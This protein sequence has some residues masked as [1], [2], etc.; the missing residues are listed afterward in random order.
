MDMRKVISAIVVAVVLIGGAAVAYMYIADVGVFEKKEVKEEKDL[1]ESKLGEFGDSDSSDEKDKGKG[2][3]KD[4]ETGS[5]KGDSVKEDEEDKNSDI[6]SALGSE[7]DTEVE[8][9]NVEVTEGKDGTARVTADTSNG[10][11]IDVFVPGQ[12]TGGEPVVSTDKPKEVEVVLENSGANKN[13]EKVKDLIE[14]AGATYSGDVSTGSF[15]VSGDGIDHV[16]SEGEEDDFNYSYSVSREDSKKSLELAA[17][18]MIKLGVRSSKSVILDSI[19][20]SLSGEG[21]E[22][23]GF[24]V[25]SDGFGTT[26]RWN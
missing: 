12:S 2:T 14:K 8:V 3:D 4:K 26:V 15:G 22:R 18:N 6:V 11:S 9:S 19:K 5:D 7:E 21:I 20:K 24:W 16:F 13:T 1:K 25:V 10:N 17:E 23:D